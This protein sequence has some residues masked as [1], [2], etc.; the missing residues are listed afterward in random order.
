MIFE[1]HLDFKIW[2]NTGL[3][4]RQKERKK[5]PTFCAAALPANCRATGANVPKSDS[6]T[7]S[8]LVKLTWIG[9]ER[10]ES[11]FVAEKTE[12]Q[13][14]RVHFSSMWSSTLC[15]S[16]YCCAP[17]P[18][19]SSAVHST[20]R[21]VLLGRRPEGGQPRKWEVNTY[22]GFNTEQWNTKCAFCDVMCV[23]DTMKR[24]T[25]PWWPCLCFSIVSSWCSLKLQEMAEHSLK[26]NTNY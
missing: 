11:H 20:A 13:T 10:R 3:Y 6:M 25:L 7:R 4:S 21:R 24:H 5:G 22:G 18:P 16:K 15:R 9:A 8:K 1:H 12:T 26:L 14:S 17:T 23:T 19:C 2:I